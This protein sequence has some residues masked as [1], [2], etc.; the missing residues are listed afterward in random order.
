MTKAKATA[1]EKAYRA[2]TGLNFPD[3]AQTDAEVRV[4]AGGTVPAA[5]V[6]ANPWLLEQGH[7][8]AEE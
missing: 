8:V 6:D 1:P 4:E 5:V 3:P 7:V 2:R